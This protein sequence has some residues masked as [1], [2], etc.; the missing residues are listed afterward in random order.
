MAS[1]FTLI[2]CEVVLLFLVTWALLRYYKSPSVSKD[3][4]IS[5][6]STWILSFAGTLL[7][8]F[9]IAV[10]LTGRDYTEAMAHLW[11]LIY[12]ST[13][14]L[15]W[16]VLPVQMAYHMS[17][18]FT[19]RGRLW[20][21]LRDNLLFFA[22]TG[23][24]F[25][26]FILYLL[27]THGV[28][29]SVEFVGFMMAMGNTYG[30][31][32]I[33]CLLG[34]GLVALPKR[35]WHMGNPTAEISRMYILANSVETSLHNARYKLEDVEAEVKE[36]LESF[37]TTATLS[38]TMRELLPLAEIIRKKLDSFDFELRSSST[39]YLKKT[40]DKERKKAAAESGGFFGF[41]GRS[42][43]N[44]AG[45]STSEV[46]KKELITLHSRLINAQLRAFSAERR[47]RALLLNIQG[48]E[49]L[50]N[51]TMRAQDC[52]WF[53]V[54]EYGSNS[55]SIHR[56][57]AENDERDQGL[58]RCFG[59]LVPFPQR[60]AR[61]YFRVID[62]VR[63]FWRRRLYR[64]A[65]RLL[66]LICAAA[67][68]LILYSELAMS[69]NLRSP[70]GFLLV[71]MSEEG[72]GL[73]MVQ[74][75]SFIYLLYMSFCTFYSFF[76]L[77]FGWNF[78]LQGN[79]QSP[80]TSLIFNA[81]YLSRLQFSL[82]YNYLLFLN[83]PKIDNTSFQNLMSNMEIVPLFGNS[84]VI[85]T[86]I[87]TVIL[88]LCTFFNVYGRFLKYLGIESEDTIV[89]DDCFHKMNEGHAEELATG[90]KLVASA[91]KDSRFKVV[92]AGRNSPVKDTVS[93][94]AG[95]MSSDHSNSSTSEDDGGDV[96]LGSFGI[97]NSSAKEVT[98]RGL[99]AVDEDEDD[100]W[101]PST[102]SMSSSRGS[103]E[104]SNPTSSAKHSGGSDTGGWGSMGGSSGRV[105]GGRYS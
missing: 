39:R 11:S 89:H 90:K 63:L 10:S 46:E 19:V 84:F 25:V 29:G 61:L 88:G 104:R 80:G 95:G 45:V 100:G 87:I 55:E 22:V 105:Y 34:N 49:N 69:T 1:S 76:K 3:T 38:H 73:F 9:D 54:K 81:T 75:V 37:D 43:D 12:W 26:I 102:F 28:S 78:T 77:N 71:N 36:V 58:C 15:A 53:G 79:Q 7:L 23:I 70:I 8:P 91:M 6:Y 101:T 59:F 40:K 68:G 14:L 42:G 62:E 92:T 17:G 57:E 13:F 44:S 83:V 30:V 67:S 47:W 52:S 85:Y 18:E 94:L 56:I 2:S 65:C 99:S 72:A 24:I 35:L 86:P 66:S 103:S 64:Y 51:N 4:I 74:S 82:G 98:K 60:V 48:E 33:I 27:A 31:L 5:T 32:L 50:L 21:A 16:I 97:R 93:L 96:E 41:F 20:E